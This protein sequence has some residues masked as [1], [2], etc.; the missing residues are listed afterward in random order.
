MKMKAT[1]PR[2]VGR[3][4]KYNEEIAKEIC[5]T[6]ATSSIGLSI[7]CKA[8]EG[9]PCE[10]TIHVW[11]NTITEF[12]EQ[13]T[14]AR[15]LQ[16]DFLADEIIA[17]ADDGRQDNEIRYGADGQPYVVEDKEW[18]GRSRLRIDARKW[19]ASKL[20]P[21]KYGD[22]VDLQHTITKVGKDLAEDEYQ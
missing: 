10:A 17:I 12:V 3:P 16:A 21:K 11:L 9:W 4:S 6:I 5:D 14:R 18:T 1:P 13:Y 7:L 19:K 22:K 8:N 2:P 20:Y 15:E